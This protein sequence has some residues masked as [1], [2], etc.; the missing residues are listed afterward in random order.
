MFILSSLN[1]I[2]SL[3]VHWEELSPQLTI[4]DFNRK[5]F[6]RLET[7]LTDHPNIFRSY[8]ESRKPKITFKKLCQTVPKSTNFNYYYIL[9]NFL[10][11]LMLTS[12]SLK[13][14]QYDYFLN[15][16][17]PINLGNRSLALIFIFQPMFTYCTLSWVKYKITPLKAYC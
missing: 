6:C 2:T 14:L 16:I 8:F 17:L 5:Y 13:F 12:L 1:I 3:K 15:C 7:L 4:F 10:V 9:Y 11:Y